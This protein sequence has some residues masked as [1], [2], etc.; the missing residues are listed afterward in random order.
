LKINNKFSK[1]RILETDKDE[2]RM[3]LEKGAPSAN[4]TSRRQ[5]AGSGVGPEVEADFWKRL[6]ENL[7]QN[8]ERFGK[9]LGKI[10]E[11]KA[12]DETDC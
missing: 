8:L 6:G 2:K 10:W 1:D 9:D 11:G 12:D 7:G 5:R 3:S 4:W